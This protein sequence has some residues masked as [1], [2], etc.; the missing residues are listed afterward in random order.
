MPRHAVPLPCRAPKG[1]ECVFPIWFT[2]CDHVCFKLTMS[3]HAMPFHAHSMPMPCSDHAVLLKAT[4]QH[5]RREAA[6]LCCGLEKIG[7]VGAWHGHGM[8][9]V[10]QTLRHCVNQMG[11]THSKHLEAR[12]DRGMA[13]YVWIGLYGS[14]PTEFNVNFLDEVT[15]RHVSP[16][17]ACHNGFSSAHTHIRPQASLHNLSDS[18]L[19]IMLEHTQGNTSQ[20]MCSNQPYCRQENVLLYHLVLFFLFLERCTKPRKCMQLK[21]SGMLG[22]VHWPVF[23]DVPFKPATSTFKR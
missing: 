22:R 17:F 11:K 6:V 2:Q 14:F 21:C 13:C 3:C 9:S 18:T 8:A 4:A 5:G 10:N 20:Q 19:N 1:L 23:T 15:L 12:H 7:M 16:G